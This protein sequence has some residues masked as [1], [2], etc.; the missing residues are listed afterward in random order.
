MQLTTYFSV[1][2]RLIPLNA[3]NTLFE[4]DTVLVINW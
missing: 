3:L 2:L 4:V 1:L